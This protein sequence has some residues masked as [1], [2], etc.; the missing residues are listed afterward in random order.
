MNKIAC[1]EKNLNNFN[2]W[3]KV[4]FRH[5][6]CFIMALLVEINNQGITSPSNFICH[7]QSVF[8]TYK[9]YGVREL[10]FCVKFKSH[11]ISN[12]GVAET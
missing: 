8:Y 2:I 1:N 3:V 7:C 5:F 4:A 6:D 11:K 9:Y 10:H 12:K